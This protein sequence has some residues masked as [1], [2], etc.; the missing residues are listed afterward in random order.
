MN[1]SR[2]PCALPPP[3]SR[4]SSSK[5]TCGIANRSPPLVTTS[6]GIIASVS[7]ILILTRGSLPRVDCT[8]TV[9][10]IFSILVLTTSMPTPR[11]ETLVTFS[12]VENPGK[13]I[14]LKIS[15]SAHALGLRAVM[16]AALHRLF[17]N[18]LRIQAR[19]IVADFNIHLAAFVEGSQDQPAGRIFPACC[20][21][22]SGSSMP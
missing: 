20:T 11:P 16:T 15:R 12:A 19:A 3:S 9:P 2:F 7:G 13:K 8:S 22:S 21:R 18:A 10:P 1:Q 6:A 14:K 4:T 5:L 17:A